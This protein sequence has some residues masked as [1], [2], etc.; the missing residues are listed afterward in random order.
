MLGLPPPSQVGP[1]GRFHAIRIASGTSLDFADAGEP[2]APQHYAFAVTE[3][4]FDAVLARIRERRIP[5]WAAP[6]QTQPDQVA[7]RGGGSRAVGGQGL[8]VQIHHRGHTS[9]FLRTKEGPS[10]APWSTTDQASS[11]LP[12]RN[13]VGLC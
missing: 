11:L 12:L 2:F 10:A 5:H 3:P 7:G 1:G 8:S 13:A 9:L 6:A 4:E